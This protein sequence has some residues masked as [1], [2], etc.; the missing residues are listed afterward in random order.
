MIYGRSVEVRA[1]SARSLYVNWLFWVNILVL[2]IFFEPYQETNLSHTNS[3]TDLLN[4]PEP[5]TQET[6]DDDEFGGEFDDETAA[7]AETVVPI[8]TE[9]KIDDDDFALPKQKPAVENV[10]SQ[11]CFARC[12]DLKDYHFFALLCWRNFAT[13]PELTMIESVQR[14]VAAKRQKLESDEVLCKGRL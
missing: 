8:D 12:T 10:S 7:P 2:L 6:F 14:L 3:T 1:L 9:E 13:L 4:S 11:S 5:Q